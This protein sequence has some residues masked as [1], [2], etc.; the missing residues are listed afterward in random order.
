VWNPAV[1]EA[2]RYHP[3]DN[4]TGA[5]PT[6]F[7]WAR[8]VYGIDANG[9]AL[10]PFDNV[11]VQYGLSQ[12]NDGTITVEQFL[13]LNENIGGYDHD[14]NFIE[15]RSSADLD[16]VQ[17]TYRSGLTL[18]ASGGLGTIPIF[19][20][21]GLYDEDQIYHY[22]W[23][24]FAVR[25]RLKEAFGDTSNH[26]M[27]RGGVSIYAYFGLGTPEELAVNQAVTSQSW[28]TFIEWMDAY[29]ADK[30]SAPRWLKVIRNKPL[31]AT[32]GCFTKSL[33]P[34]FIKELQT[35]S[36]EPDT[37][38][39]SIW[40]SWSAPRIEAG[41]PVSGNV[42]K[43]ELKPLN[44]KDYAVSF[45]DDEWARLQAIFPS[46]ACDWS[47]QGIG[48]MAVETFPSFGPSSANLVY[49]ITMP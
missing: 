36:S 32:D 38:C 44:E 37:A 41:G 33:N 14:S 34:Q 28:D 23:F 19:D 21:S 16:A 26:V 48:Q 1:P 31:M 2:L 45:T 8:N 25:E 39:N 27:W 29:M 49:D 17:R 20:I 3:T 6:I 10:R 43:C 47:Q 13:D 15:A 30:S 12:L 46:G 4:P 24:H 11:G 7:D 42:L 22:Q 5:R 35:L 18:G 40:P 9:F